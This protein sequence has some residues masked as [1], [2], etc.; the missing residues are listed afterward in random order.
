[1]L[2][3]I[4]T[5]MTLSV[6]LSTTSPELTSAASFL[7]AVCGRASGDKRDNMESVGKANVAAGDTA[8]STANELPP[9]AVLDATD[10]SPPT[11]PLPRPEAIAE[12]GGNEVEMEESK[13][14]ADVVVLDDTE[15][16]VEGSSGDESKS[17]SSLGGISA[18]SYGSR[19]SRK[20][21]AEDSPERAFGEPLRQRF[22]GAI[23]RGAGGCRIYVPAAAAAKGGKEGTTTEIRGTTMPANETAVGEELPVPMSATTIIPLSVVMRIST[24]S[25]MEATE[26]V[27]PDCSAHSDMPSSDLANTVSQAST[28]LGTASTVMGPLRNQGHPGTDMTTVNSDIATAELQSSCA[29]ATPIVAVNTVVNIPAGLLAS[30]SVRAPIDEI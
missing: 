21:A 2:R 20:R 22:P 7:S 27:S 9:N 17:S 25:Y 10:V 1:M 19:A 28:K 11:R 12:A 18:S 6:H 16:S 15:M 26:R 29:G 23:T 14:D 8:V 4:N 30:N 24:S 13:D 5:T 3:E